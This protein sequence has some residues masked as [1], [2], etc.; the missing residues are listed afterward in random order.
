MCYKRHIKDK[1]AD[2]IEIVEQVVYDKFQW[3]LTYKLFLH[4]YSSTLI[5]YQFM[6]PTIPHCW[7]YCGWLQDPYSCGESI[8]KDI[9]IF[10]TLKDDLLRTKHQCG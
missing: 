2:V 8:L 9:A 4:G 5:E 1:V 10:A 7:H 3:N 6:G